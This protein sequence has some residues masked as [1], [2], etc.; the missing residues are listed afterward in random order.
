M[1]SQ[2]EN[3]KR[4]KLIFEYVG[5]QKKKEKVIIYLGRNSTELF[6]EQVDVI[7]HFTKVS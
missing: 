7:N 5:E 1:F 2:Q 3:Q 6:S 4:P